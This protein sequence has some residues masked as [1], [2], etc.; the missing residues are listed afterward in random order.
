MIGRLKLLDCKTNLK[1]LAFPF[2]SLVIIFY[3]G[4]TFYTGY[5]FKTYG[6]MKKTNDKHKSLVMKKQIENKH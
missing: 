3:M 2:A 1:V 5:V 6:V 4:L